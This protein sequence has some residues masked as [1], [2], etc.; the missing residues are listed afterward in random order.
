MSS[1]AATVHEGPKRALL[2]E[3]SA[4]DRQLGRT[5]RTI[6]EEVVDL[7]E[8]SVLPEDGVFDL[9][10][11][12]ADG[13]DERLRACVE[14]FG[15]RGSKTRLLVCMS[16]A[17][18]EELADLFHETSLC[19]LMAKNDGELNVDE[20]IVTVRKIFSGD[21]FGLDKYFAWGAEV[22]DFELSGTRDKEAA[23][24]RVTAFAESLR[25][26]KRLSSTL[27]TVADELVTNALY[28]APMSR[29]G[30]PR[31]AH[32][33]RNE[34]VMLEP[35][36]QVV[37]QLCSDGRRLG[38]SAR[39]PFGSL[40][41]QRVLEYL[42]KCLR[43]GSDQ[44]DDKEGGAGLG[45]YFIFDAAAH[46]VVNVAPGSSTEMIG[47]IDIATGFRGIASRSK[48]FNLF[49]DETKR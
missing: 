30:A 8:G 24:D 29:E 19:N 5:L 22:T 11:A 18:D 42:V 1:R 16:G 20:L 26:T 49:V 3:L 44:V 45:L 10:V 14:R 12:T 9:V 27:C 15:R 17:S 4:R 36:E 39:D 32:L 34:P 47:L 6:V 46:F 2:V 33:H 25:L 43:R 7:V 41:P 38:I 48:S 40:Q 21:V 13:L 31:F 35:G 28:N 37:M 23:L